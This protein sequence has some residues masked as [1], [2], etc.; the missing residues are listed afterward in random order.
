MVHVLLY[1]WSVLSEFYNCVDV[2]HVVHGLYTQ[3]YM[4]CLQSCHYTLYTVTVWRFEVCLSVK[5]LRHR[6]WYNYYGAVNAVKISGNLMY[7]HVHVHVSMY[8]GRCL[9]GV[10]WQIYCYLWLLMKWVCVCVC[11]CVCVWIYM[12]CVYMYVS[13]GGDIWYNH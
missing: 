5:N 9:L 13:V 2:V 11:V 12:M 4:K 10:G 3:G 6:W 1:R 8:G 7:I